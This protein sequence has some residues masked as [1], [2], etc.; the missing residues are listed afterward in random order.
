[1]YTEQITQRLGITAPVNNQTINSGGTAT[2][3]AGPVDMSKFHRAFFIV[4][5]GTVV[6]GGNVTL[7]L[8]ESNN[9]NLTSSSNCQGS[10]TSI[11]GLTTSNQQ[12]TLEIRADQMTKRY[13]GLQ[14]TETSG[15][16]GHNVAI[17]IVGFGD[18]AG[19]KPGNV[20]NDTSVASQ[21]VV[22]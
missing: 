20:S 7:Q 4:D 21:K 1:V 6:S 22:S 8:I 12:Y 13:L 2:V 10:N 3:T 5:I 15:G 16:G 17:T 14:A 11:T 9:S 18:E 19:H